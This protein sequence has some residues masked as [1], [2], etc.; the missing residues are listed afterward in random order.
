ML[1]HMSVFICVAMPRSRSAVR[2]WR[3]VATRSDPGREHPH[4]SAAHHVL[5]SCSRV[6]HAEHTLRS[7]TPEARLALLT[8]HTPVR[9]AFFNNKKRISLYS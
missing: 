9:I 8:I 5:T 6:V 4:A 1:R 3:V 7:T 2:S